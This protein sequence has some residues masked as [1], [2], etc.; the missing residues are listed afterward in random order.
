MSLLSSSFSSI[1]SFADANTPKSDDF[2]GTLDDG[3]WGGGAGNVGLV[4]LGIIRVD[5]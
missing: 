5:S 2:F 3:G 1:S 4:E